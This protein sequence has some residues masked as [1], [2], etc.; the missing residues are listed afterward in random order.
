MICYLSGPITGLEKCE[1]TYW[2]N[3]LQEKLESRGIKVLDPCRPTV[4]PMEEGDSCLFRDFLDVERCDLI[5]VNL[6]QKTDRLSIGTIAEI[7]WAYSM[8]KPMIILQADNG[9][10][11]YLTHPF[12]SKTTPFLIRNHGETLYT[13]LE[14]A[15]DIAASI[16]GV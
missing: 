8:G 6:M 15:A 13:T 4:L 9:R 2:R 16:L 12:I 1:M 7:H 14:Q 11:E 3:I 10:S 5:I